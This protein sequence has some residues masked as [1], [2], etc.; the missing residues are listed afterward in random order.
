MIAEEIRKTIIAEL[1]KILKSDKKIQAIAIRLLKE[2]FADKKETDNRFDKILKE[3]AEDRKLQYLKWQEQNRKW[4]EQMAESERK[5]QEQNKK[6]EE[7]NR[8]W[9]QLKIE[10]DKKWEEL[11]KRW[12]AKFNATIGA[13]GARWGKKTEQT[14]RNALIGILRDTSGLE[15]I[16]VTE[17]DYN[18]EVFGRPDQIELDLIIKNG[19]LYI[20]EIKSSTSKA[21]VLIFKKKADF[22]QKLHQRKADKLIIISPMFDES[23]K[24]FAIQEGISIYR[25]IDEAIND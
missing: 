9:E 19:L 25:D 24:S 23:A 21:D 18:G 11:N 2:K 14:F 12:D 5:W 16:N 15:V 7:Q 22:Y 13:I 4:E 20:C 1:P 10:S 17:Y 8:R 3:L 6:W